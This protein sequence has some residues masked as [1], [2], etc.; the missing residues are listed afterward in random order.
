[1]LAI[2]SLYPSLF[3]LAWIAFIPLLHALHRSDSLFLAYKLGFVSGLTLYAISTY[4]LVDFIIIFKEYDKVLAVTISS[5]YWI[6]CAQMIAIV[7]MLTWY[8]NRIYPL[9]WLFPL[10]ITIVFAYFPTL[11]SVQLGETQSDFLVALQGISYTGV[12]GL[13][14]IIT[15]FNVLLFQA[16]IGK[17]ELSKRALSI[18]YGVIVV[19]FAFGMYS[20]HIREP[21]INDSPVLTVGIVQ[22]NHPAKAPHPGAQPGYTLSYPIEMSLTD[23]L[24]E[25]NPD[26]V[27]WPENSAKHYYKDEYLRTTFI[28]NINALNVPVIFHGYETQVNQ[29]KFQ[30][31]STTTYIDKKG[32][33]GDKYQKHKLIAFAEYLPFLFDFHTLKQPLSKYLGDFFSDLKPGLEPKVFRTDKANV[34]PLICYEIMFSEY[35]AYRVVAAENPDIL[36]TQSNNSWF[37]NTRQPFQHVSSS[38]LRSVENRLP[39]VHVVNNGP[40]VVILPSGRQIMKSDYQK[41]AA[42]AVDIPLSGM[43]S[44]SFYSNHPYLFI[45]I[46][47]IVLLVMILH[48]IFHRSIRKNNYSPSD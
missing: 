32:R 10:L 42:Y 45:A 38:A 43:R 31:Y 2:A 14:F 16:L 24:A 22:S 29:G 40:S 1:M 3:L 9:T 13:D 4:W 26:I 46:L 48:L 39:M 27:I 37:G 17:N 28:K 12:S 23:R 35:V 36:I 20:L 5:L 18:A 7:A 11:F 33:L 47:T 19:W 44:R 34:I 25:N 30:H 8:L 41:T 15:L 21:Y 6:Y